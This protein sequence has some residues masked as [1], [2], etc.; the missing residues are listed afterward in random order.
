MVK[1]GPKRDKMEQDISK[2][3]Y[4]MIQTIEESNEPLNTEPLLM[5]NLGNVVF[6]LVFGKTWEKNDPIW[7]KLQRYQEEGT[8]MIGVAGPINFLPFLR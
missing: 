7:L 6:N 4:E 3:I 2:G 5:H 1:F 8:K